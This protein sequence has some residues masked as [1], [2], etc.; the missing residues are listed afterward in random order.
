MEKKKKLETIKANVF[1]I[2]Q[3]I[4]QM[5]VLDNEKFQQEY[6]NIISKF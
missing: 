3:L 4:S 6:D 5:S 1:K 2:F